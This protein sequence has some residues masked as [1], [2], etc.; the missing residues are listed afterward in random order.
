MANTLYELGRQKF[1]DGLI[2]WTGD[3]IKVA[4]VDSAVYT[5]NLVTD[6]F[7]TDVTAG[8][9]VIA[10]SSNLTSTAN[11]FG[12][13]DAADVTLSSVTGAVSEYLVCYKD[14]GTPATSP[15]IGVIDSATGLPV[16]PNGG[17]ISIQWDNGANKIFKL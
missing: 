17:D 16:T 10:T 6:E 1:A 12:V 7:I 13:C 5:I 2:S 8:G 3:N 9:A 11:V 15:L 4:L 14:T